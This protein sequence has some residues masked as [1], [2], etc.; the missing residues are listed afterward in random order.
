MM[1]ADAM[2]AITFQGVESLTFE[3]VADPE[4]ETPN[5]V[6]IEVELAG[7]CGSDLHPYLGREKGLDVG[8]VMGHE[9]IGRIVECGTAV[10]R[11]SE[12]DRVVGPFTTNCGHCFY[13][14][15][16]LTCRCETG[17]LFGWREQ[18]RGLHGSQ[19]EL[20]RV[21]LADSTLVRVDEAIPADSAL[22]VGDILA[23]GFYGAELARV[24]GGDVAVVIGCGPVG[25]MAILGAREL[26][27]SVVLALDTVSARLELADRFGARSVDVSSGNALEAVLE[28]TEGRG[29]DRVLEA[30]GSPQATRLAVDLVR[31]GGSIAAIGVHTEETFA[32]AP[33]EA[34]DKNLT[35]SAGRCPVRRYTERLLEI[36]ASGR[37]DLGTI[38]S[39]RLPL[40]EGVEGYRMF[41][42][43][44]D[45]CTK[46]VLSP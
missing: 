37:Y 13:C 33:G 3:S 8:T 22:F 24:G 6:V 11:H 42:E 2:R 17:Q 15:R 40:S 10:S 16:S 23:T 20:M 35:Y 31:P 18:G 7:I 44:R 41:A 46:V 19:A 14:E 36:V 1:P 26:G 39:H 34:Y 9:Y 21:P 45:G 43:R 25:L 12:G 5:D 29:A 32:F 30:V 4:I 28:A 38:V 27:A